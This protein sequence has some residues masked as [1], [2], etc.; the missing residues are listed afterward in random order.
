MVHIMP[1]HAVTLLQIHL[2]RSI[3]VW[4][5]LRRLTH[6][7]IIIII[8]FIL[9]QLNIPIVQAEFRTDQIERTLTFVRLIKSQR[10]PF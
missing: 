6:H 8:I 1:T 7:T 4:D 10:K 5:T 9:N 2:K 3:F